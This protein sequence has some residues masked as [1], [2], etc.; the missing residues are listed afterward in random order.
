M[1]SRKKVEVVRVVMVGKD[2]LIPGTTE[3]IEFRSSSVD[4]TEAALAMQRQPELQ[5][6]RVVVFRDCSVKRRVRR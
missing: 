6:K 2:I 5:G 4:L 3:A 1:A